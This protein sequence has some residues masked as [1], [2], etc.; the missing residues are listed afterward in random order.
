MLFENNSE[1]LAY[2]L[3]GV[4][5]KYMRDRENARADQPRP[6]NQAYN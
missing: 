3:K 2:E 6:K 4:K 5:P 1:H